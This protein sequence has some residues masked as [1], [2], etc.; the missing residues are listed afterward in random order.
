MAHWTLVYLDAD[1]AEEEAAELNVN[2]IPALR[3]HTMLGE[4]V[5]AQDGLVSAEEL[6][7]WLKK[8]YE[9]ASAEADEVLLTDGEPDAAAVVRLIRQFQQRNPAIREAAIRRLA[10]YPQKARLGVINAFGKAISR[11]VWPPWNSCG[12]GGPRSPIS[13]PGNR[14]A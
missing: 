10:P 2:G 1:K 6:V 13:I 12:N 5:A 7:S 3:I 8:Q 9:A 11:G 4:S 14:K